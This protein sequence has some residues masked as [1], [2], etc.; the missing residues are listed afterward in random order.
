LADVFRGFFN[1]S[2]THSTLVDFWKDSTLGLVDIAGSEVFGWYDSGYTMIGSAG[3]APYIG[4]SEGGPSP[5]RG[6]LVAHARVV[7]Q[8]NNPGLDL[9]RFRS[10]LAVYNFDLNAGQSGEDVVYGLKP[11]ALSWAQGKWNPCATCSGL[12]R[13][14]AAASICAGS[15]GSTPFAHTKNGDEVQVPTV[16]TLLSGL[17]G[18]STCR[19]CGVLYELA[20]ANGCPAGGAHADDGSRFYLPSDWASTFGSSG[21]Q[22]CQD[23]GLVL[24]PGSQFLCPVTRSAHVTLSENFS[25]SAVALAAPSLTWM[26]HEM[27]H[28]Y[29]FIHGRSTQPD[30]TDLYDDA[31]PGAYGDRYDIMSAMD[32]AWFTD[33]QGYQAGPALATHQLLPMTAVPVQVFDPSKAFDSILIRTPD[34]P[35]SG[36]ILARMG[37]FVAEL[38]MHNDPR[39]L[40]GWDRNLDFGDPNAR[41]GV[42]IHNLEPFAPTLM[43]S[44]KGKPYLLEGEQFLTREGE[45]TIAIEVNEIDEDSRT[46]RLTVWNQNILA[47]G[48][49]QRW[50]VIPCTYNGDPTQG[51]TR[52]ELDGLLDDVEGYWND[53]SGGGSNIGG[54]YVLQPARPGILRYVIPAAV[55]DVQNQ[56]S[57]QRVQTIIERVRNDLSPMKSSTF[58]F[59][60]LPRFLDWRWFTGIIVISDLP[61]TGGYL[62][63][64][65][66]SSGN[67]PKSAVTPGGGFNAV[68]QQPIGEG[69]GSL[70]FDVI[71]AGLDRATAAAL[72]MAVGASLALQTATGD[73]YHLMNTDP[74]TLREAT[75]DKW[76]PNGPFISTDQMDSLGWLAGR[77]LVV[78]IP[79]EQNFTSG[80][81]TLVALTKRSEEPGLLR[82]NLGPVRCECRYSEGLDAALPAGTVVLVWDSSGVPRAL[83]Q[84]E[85]ISWVGATLVNG[86]PAGL[87]LKVFGGGSLTVIAA[88]SSGA[89]IGY[90][91]VAGMRLIEVPVPWE[92]L[93]KVPPG[94]P[95]EKRFQNFVN[96]HVRPSA[97][98][99]LAEFAQE[100]SRQQGVSAAQNGRDLRPGEAAPR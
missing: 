42:L 10:I 94:D 2:L 50:L 16:S 41:A 54:H 83:R 23:C 73:P 75:A 18:F 1:P 43:T 97:Q 76:S 84:G 31:S 68:A 64:L 63:S 85:S 99:L 28:A 96:E 61:T 67:L 44:T 58:P 93:M 72:N 81:A 65:R 82:V 12:F 6:D 40:P 51:A 37:N 39:G 78:Q 62:G 74:D 8:Q 69:F 60:P 49:L 5:V 45:G 27:G 52:D 32:C 80:R 86:A 9:S 87:P 36:P 89:T 14:D 57:A 77:D 59:L 30:S 88:D 29:G 47:T 55:D 7:L 56:T 20:R 35:G 17:G 90:E 24:Q 70:N 48:A 3:L 21:W 4:V 71:E 26:C 33:D 15:V 100:V 92:I 25:F 46:A 79:Y 11:G 53:V 13:S 95:W 38:R 19:R 91:A 22:R 34:S 66:L 98:R